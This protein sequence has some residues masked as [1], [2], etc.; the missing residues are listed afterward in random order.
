MFN[1]K[2]PEPVIVDSKHSGAFQRD[3]ITVEVAIYRLEEEEMEWS[4]EV[5]DEHGNSTVWD[6]TFVSDDA[7]WNAFMEA[8]NEEGI[9]S[10]VAPI[11]DARQVH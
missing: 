11:D 3:G 10:I 9:A 4:L 6:E 1:P 8:I 2:Q 7:A 5:I